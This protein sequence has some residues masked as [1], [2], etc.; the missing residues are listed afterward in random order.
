MRK[1]VSLLHCTT[2][3][4]A[5]FEEINLK[6]MQTFQ[7]AFGLTV[8]YSDHTVGI[9]VPIAAVAC[10]AEIIEKH[11]TLDKAMPGPDHSASLEPQELA[12]MI[13]GI[14]QVELAMGNS[15]KIPTFSEIKNRSIARKSL[16]SLAPI[17][18]GEMFSEKN[19]GCK[20]PGNGVSPLN[21]YLYKGKY[22][23]RDY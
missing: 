21:F 9:A 22:A 23:D 20:R 18:K 8:G 19:I 2:E 14:R 13:M 7:S 11:F 10:G 12:A 17:K 3:Y 4:P 15:K 1:K 6:V 5:P 16:V